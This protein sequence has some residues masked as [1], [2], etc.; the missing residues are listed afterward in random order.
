MAKSGAAWFDN[1]TDL[2]ERL[3]HYGIDWA[4]RSTSRGTSTARAYYKRSPTPPPIPETV[5]E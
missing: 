3:P 4:G 5:A 1:G 2:D